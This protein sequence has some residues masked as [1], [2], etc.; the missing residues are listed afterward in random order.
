[1]RV[2]PSSHAGRVP[3]KTFGERLRELRQAKSLSQRAL[4]ERV[5][6]NFRYLFRCE[7]GT[8][9]FAQYPSE[10]LILWLATALE[11]DE[12]E[13][14]ILAKKVP[15]AIRER[16]FERPDVFGKLARLDDARLDDVLAESTA[17][18]QKERSV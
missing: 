18:V 11:A 7:T 3:V 17:L 4:A 16:V 10:D 12:D 5:G 8:L 2:N 14:L 6:V 9:D 13:L 1:M 15:P